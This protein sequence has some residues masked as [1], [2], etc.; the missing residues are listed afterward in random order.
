MC[1]V[2]KIQFLLQV[3]NKQM[4]SEKNKRS[5]YHQVNTKK[6]LTESYCSVLVLLRLLASKTTR[7]VSVFLSGRMTS[8]HSK[9]TRIFFCT[10]IIPKK[11]I[12]LPKSS[13]GYVFRFLAVPSPKIAKTSTASK[14]THQ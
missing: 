3:L 12:N 6:K 13:F 9:K 14:A 4:N 1:C 10:I 2:R 5:G 11:K 8:N 7:I